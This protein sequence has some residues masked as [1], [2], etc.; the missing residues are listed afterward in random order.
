MH[1]TN[2]NV[3]YEWRTFL[4]PQI[5]LVSLDNW[6]YDMYLFIT[7]RSTKICKCNLITC[8]SVSVL[9]SSSSFLWC[10]FVCRQFSHSQKFWFNWHISGHEHDTWTTSC[11]SYEFCVCVCERFVW[12][13]SLYMKWRMQLESNYYC[14]E[15]Y[16]KWQ[17]MVWNILFFLWNA[18]SGMTATFHT[19][20]VHVALLL[21][22]TQLYFVAN[23]MPYLERCKRNA[24]YI[25]SFK[26]CLKV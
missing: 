16:K 12:L 6:M 26:K 4:W 7:H 10:V 20:R 3:Y 18:W 9:F 1:A 15:L 2:R 23:C 11:I 14:D 22:S 21:F 25:Y 24:C 13:F 17:Q 5:C 8:C 19:V